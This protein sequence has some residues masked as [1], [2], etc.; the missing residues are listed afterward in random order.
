MDEITKKKHEKEAA[1]R[2]KSA[3]FNN[4]FSNEN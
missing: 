4:N 2:S 1:A 3:E